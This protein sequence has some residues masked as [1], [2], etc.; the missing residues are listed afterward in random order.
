[1]FGPLLEPPHELLVPEVRRQP[2]NPVE[3]TFGRDAADG[4]RPEPLFVDTDPAKLAADLRSGGL[5]RRAHEANEL[6]L[7]DAGPMRLTLRVRRVATSG[8]TRRLLHPPPG[9]RSESRPVWIP[10]PHLRTPL[11]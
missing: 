9:G 5:V 8:R 7:L 3:Q 10:T 2:A 11:A 6:R 1:M 4:E